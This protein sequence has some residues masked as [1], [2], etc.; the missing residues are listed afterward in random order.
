MT[1]LRYLATFTIKQSAC[2]VC[3]K[4]GSTRVCVCVCSWNA[5]PALETRRHVHS[6]FLTTHK[7]RCW[8]PIATPPPPH[9]SR[10]VAGCWWWVPVQTA[11]EQLA[12]HHAGLDA[13]ILMTR[14][15]ARVLL[16]VCALH[17]SDTLCYLLWTS[18]HKSIAIICPFPGIRFYGS[19]LFI[20]S[21][22]IFACECIF[23]PQWVRKRNCGWDEFHFCGWQ[24][25]MVAQV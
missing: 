23:C 5:S 14:R 20:I 25:Y 4:T 18:S 1:M 12:C 9:P 19:Y 17:V 8:L 2:N 11:G 7:A 10:K 21:S 15:E 22:S 13:Q 6:S 3:L 24:K 16:E